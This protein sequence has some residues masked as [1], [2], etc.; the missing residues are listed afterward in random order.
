MVGII[1]LPDNCHCFVVVVGVIVSVARYCLVLKKKLRR[2]YCLE[3]H[4]L[5]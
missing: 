2:G 4:S 1:A 5:C 3:F